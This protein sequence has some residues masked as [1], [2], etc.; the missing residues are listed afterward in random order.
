MRVAQVKEVMNIRVLAT[1]NEVIVMYVIKLKNH[2]SPLTYSVKS[3]ANL[4]ISK[5]SSASKG[6]QSSKSSLSLYSFI[7]V[8]LSPDPNSS[9]K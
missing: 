4:S 5:L 1:V 8:S 3:E 9:M 7:C 6:L 2:T